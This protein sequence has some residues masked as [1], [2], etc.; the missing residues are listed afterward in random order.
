MLFAFTQANR[1][2]RLMKVA[3][4]AET[5]STEASTTSASSHTG[6]GARAI[7]EALAQASGKTTEEILGM[8]SSGHGFGRIAR[9]LGLKVGTI[10]S[11][12]FVPPPP[13]AA[14]PADGTSTGEDPV[15]DP[16][17]TEGTPSIVD[18][19]V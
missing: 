6:R 18:Q 19:R 10:R 2:D 5:S 3:R 16:V 13:V 11:G 4:T 14:P 17:S 7:A 9:D 1:G 12:R 8:R 15:V